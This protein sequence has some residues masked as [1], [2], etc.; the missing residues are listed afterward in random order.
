MGRCQQ[1]RQPLK[2]AREPR[3]RRGRATRRRDRRDR[4]LLAGHPRSPLGRYANG[5][6][7]ADRWRF[8]TDDP[9][10]TDEPYLISNTYTV[11][12]SV[13]QTSAHTVEISN[14][15]LGNH[16]AGDIFGQDQQLAN[17]ITVPGDGDIT[18]HISL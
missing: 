3:L 2:H 15:A 1:G 10:G 17:N 6:G 12:P 4:R 18:V 9:G 5:T 13:G 14:D 16:E 7:P 11:D 8:T